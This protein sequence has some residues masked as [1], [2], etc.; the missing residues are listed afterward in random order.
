MSAYLDEITMAEG[1]CAITG[2]L[3]LKSRKDLP[4][5]LL[6]SYVL[7]IFFAELFGAYLGKRYGANIWYYNLL[8][9]VQASFF[10]YTFKNILDKLTKSGP[11]ILSA[12]CLVLIAYSYDLITHG[13]QTRHHLA[14]TVFGLSMVSCALYYFYLLLVSSEYIDLKT[15]ATFWW[16]AGTLLFF[17]PVSVINIFGTPLRKILLNPGDTLYITFKVLNIILYTSWIY[18]FICKKWE[19]EN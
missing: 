8:L 19:P 9:L 10:F 13:P 18:A 5:T 12:L 3:C 7:L 6:W 2:Y 16:V 4:T 17:F 11:L 1:I 14:H 15:S